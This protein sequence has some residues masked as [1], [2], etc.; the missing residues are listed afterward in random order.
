MFYTIWSILLLIDILFLFVAGLVGGI[1]NSIAGGG[2]FITFPALVF[3][4]ISPLMANATN[5]FAS[6]AGY[7]SGAYAF[8]MKLIRYKKE[9]LTTVL[10]SVV[11]GFIGAYLLLK[12]PES[13]FELAIPWLLLFATLLFI[14][15]NKA[16]G[17]LQTYAANN[18]YVLRFTSLFLWCLLLIICVYGGFFNAGLGIIVLSYLALAGHKN[19]NVMNGLKLVVSAAVS[20][21]AIVFFVLNHSIAWL[22]GCSVLAGTLLGGYYSAQLSMKLNEDYIRWF[23]IAMSLLI[24]LYFF[25]LTY[26]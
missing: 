20:L 23:V 24:T 17:L 13:S 16:N 25:Y 8:R 15:G 14:F 26:A 6:C 12:T 2:S 22:E 11:G 3:V 21:A 9:V 7:I 1:L 18:N 19:I 10:L 4:G 5:T